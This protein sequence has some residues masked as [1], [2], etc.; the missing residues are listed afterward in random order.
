MM[1]KPGTVA[2]HEECPDCRGAGCE[3]VDPAPEQ[4]RMKGNPACGS[5]DVHSREHDKTRAC[6]DI[7]P[8][9][10]PVD[11]PEQQ[12]SRRMQANRGYGSDH[13]HNKEHDE[14]RGCSYPPACEPADPPAPPAAPAKLRRMQA[15]R[16][17]VGTPQHR[18]KTM[19][20]FEKEL[21]HLINRHSIENVVDM[22]DY[23]LAEMICRMIEAMG[24]SIKKTLN[25]HGCDSVC[26]PSPNVKGE[27]QT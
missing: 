12:P 13:I 19:E 21:T 14:T 27:A 25:W 8:Y 4:Q 26:H 5:A 22:P 24:P 7:K 2:P 15:N 20:A 16:G 18:R 10:E 1:L 3:P 9:C 17:V 23:L 11:P 6:V